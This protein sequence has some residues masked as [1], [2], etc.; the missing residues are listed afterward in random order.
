MSFYHKVLEK[1]KDLKFLK[2]ERGA[3]LVLTALLL[4][5][6]FGCLGIGYDIGNL[7]MHKARL[8]N[9]ADA[10]ALAGGRAYLDS[11]TKTTGVKD[12]IDDNTS[13][14]ADQEYVIGGSKTRGGKHP[15]ADRA[16]DEYIYRNIINLGEKVY[17]DKYSHYALKGL[18]KSGENYAVADEIFYRIGLYETVPLRFLPL[19]TNKYN[20]TVRAGA[21]ALIQPGTTTTTGGGGNVTTI[22]HPSM[23]DNLYTYSEYFDAGLANANHIHNATYEGNMVFTYG[24][25]NSTKEHFYDIVKITGGHT[26]SVDHLFNN[27]SANLAAIGGNAANID[28]EWA[29]VNDPIINTYFNTEAYV[30]AF[31]SK[32]NLPHYDVNDQTLNVTGNVTSNST[33]RLK[34]V[35][36]SGEG[37]GTY[38]KV[39][40]DY[41]LLNSNGERI[42]FENNGKTYTVCYHK[43][44]DSNYVVRC[45]KTEGDNT[46]YV[47]TAD[48]RITNCS[49]KMVQPD[50]NN[51]YWI[52]EALCLGNDTTIIHYQNGTYLDSNWQPTISDNR[53]SPSKPATPIDLNNF[54]QQ[55]ASGGSVS[56]NVYHVSSTFYGNV[57]NLTLNA[58]GQMSG[59]SSEPIYVIVEPN[60][61]HIQINIKNNSRPIIFVYFGTSNVLIN[62]NGITPDDVAKLTIYAPYGTAG[63][64]P[65]LEQL[66]YSGTFRGNVIARRIAIQASGGSFSKWIQENHLENTSYTDE[67]VAAVTKTIEDAIKNS[68]KLP[69]DIRETVMQRYANALNMNP[70]NMSDPLFY[71]KLGYSSKQALYTTW[72]SLLNEFP[73]YAN[74]LWPWNEHF[75][76]QSG[77]ET[78][79]TGETLRLINYRTEYQTKADGS[80]E[81][82]KVLD[83]FIFETLGK[84]N[85][86]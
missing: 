84:P 19:L 81:D 3:I 45:G 23:F 1:I 61:T 60:I 53:F 5:I 16:A 69:D 85:S 38:D 36:S 40:D 50:P 41:Y 77:E 39:N 35:V 54:Q 68:T 15:D 71:S 28:G 75:N 57:P 34:Y 17:S 9:V 65:D 25:G 27:S 74:Q 82:G 33:C 37:Q 13:G 12:T 10:A 6:I 79:T 7:Y 62:N 86:Y 21:V 29:K 24:N 67:A 48:N 11:Q 31:K 4:P 30:D 55:A 56:T 26:Q 47:L 44:P 42:T 80:I 51:A 78:V 52:T 72:R 49:I 76:V 22:T 20:E 18:K 73:A 83:P 59:S 63:I 32:L 64:N 46:Y 58:I 2:Q 43:I 14:N 70:E 8:Q 66:N